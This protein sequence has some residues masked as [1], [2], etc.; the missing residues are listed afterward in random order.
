[1][2]RPASSKLKRPTHLSYPEFIEPDKS[3]IFS[4]NQNR[5]SN[6]KD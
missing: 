6:E 5:N 2:N 3:N 1:M 4:T